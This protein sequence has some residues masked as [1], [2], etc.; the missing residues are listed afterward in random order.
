MSEETGQKGSRQMSNRMWLFF[1]ILLGLFFLLRG[2]WV[3]AEGLTGNTKLDQRDW[4]L[5]ALFLLTG[6]RLV[7]FVFK[8][9]R[10][11]PSLKAE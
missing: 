4:L 11:N 7:F 10:P 6:M 5:V 1:A 3:G 2:A 8:K 9:M